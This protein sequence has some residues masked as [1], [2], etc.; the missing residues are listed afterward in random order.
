M[1]FV[2][3]EL[4][5]LAD[6]RGFLTMPRKSPKRR[7]VKS[8]ITPAVN[9]AAD[10]RERAKDFLNEGEITAFLSATKAGGMGHAT[11]CCCS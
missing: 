1:H 9:A 10:E 8:A 2:K 5:G 4:S 11:I 6:Q 3:R 7:N